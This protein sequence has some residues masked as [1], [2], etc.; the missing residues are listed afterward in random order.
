VVIT[1]PTEFAIDLEY[2]MDMEAPVLV[3]KG[4]NL[5][6]AQIKEIAR[7]H[8]IPVVE[9]VIAEIL[10]AIWRAQARAGKTATG[11]AGRS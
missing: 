7:W 8:G 5:L 3:A 2:R 11:T 9:T 1:N 10:A 4:R 6:A